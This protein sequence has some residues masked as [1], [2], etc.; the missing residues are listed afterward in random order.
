MGLGAQ[1]ALQRS[2]QLTGAR[3]DLRIFKAQQDSQDAL[4][5]LQFGGQAA[6]FIGQGADETGLFALQESA[7]LDAAVLGAEMQK[8]AADKAADAQKTAGILGAVGGIA[9]GIAGLF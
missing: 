7:G 1:I 2:G 9:G 8:R 6:A 4:R 3:R 5:R